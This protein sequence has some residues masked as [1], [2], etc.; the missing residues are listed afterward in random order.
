MSKQWFETWFNEDYEQIYAHRD[1][2]EARQI[3]NLFENRVGLRYQN[4]QLYLDLCCG[5]GRVSHL[6]GEYAESGA[7]N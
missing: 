5:L 6:L 7:R 3:I 1:D 2:K 4:H